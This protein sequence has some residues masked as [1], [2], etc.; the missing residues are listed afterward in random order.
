MTGDA[1]YD[2]KNLEEI[3][4]ICGTNKDKKTFTGNVLVEGEEI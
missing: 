1:T 4:E 3:Y 2:E